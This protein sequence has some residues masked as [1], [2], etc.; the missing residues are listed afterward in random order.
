[1]K[2][3]LNELSLDILADNRQEVEQAMEQIANI[4]KEINQMLHKS[5]RILTNVSFKEQALTQDHSL[6]FMQWFKTSELNQDDKR[7]VLNALAQEP[8]FRDVPPYYFF[9]GKD[10]LGFGYAFENDW[11]SISY[12][13]KSNWLSDSYEVERIE[14]ENE[15]V[16]VIRNVTTLENLQ[17]WLEWLKERQK[18]EEALELLSIT[19][20]AI[21]WERRTTLFP[22]LDFCEDVR[23]QLDE[24]GN[25]W[26]GLIVDKLLVFNEYIEKIQGNNFD[27]DNIPLNASPEGSTTLNQNDSERTFICPDGK[28]R[29]F[30]WHI[31]FSGKRIHFCPMDNS[32]KCYVGYIGKKL[33]TKKFKGN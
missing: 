31:K 29:L 5:A 2:L 16:V 20:P 32:K 21:F 13:A 10:C 18:Q 30:N 14:D 22:Q 15:E 28:Y 6:N 17:H 4:L 27:F 23:K 19:S 12:D 11:A 1:M 25:N 8:M 24:L 9:S 7:R 33:S 26:L 3:I